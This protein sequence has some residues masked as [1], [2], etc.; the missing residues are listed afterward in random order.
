MLPLSIT[1]GLVPQHSINGVSA[2]YS[3]RYPRMIATRLSK[4]LTVDYYLHR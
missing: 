3:I 4:F 1:D 2:G